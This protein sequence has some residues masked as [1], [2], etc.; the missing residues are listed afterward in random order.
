MSETEAVHVTYVCMIGQVL[1]APHNLHLFDY[2]SS[3]WESSID[4]N[5]SMPTELWYV[6]IPLLI[7][8]LLYILSCFITFYHLDPNFIKYTISSMIFTSMSPQISL[9]TS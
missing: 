8:N 3:H 7:Y 2:Y 1:L 5:M 9:Y 6:V 4:N